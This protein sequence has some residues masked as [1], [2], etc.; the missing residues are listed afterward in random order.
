VLGASVVDGWKLSK[1]GTMAVSAQ[2]GLSTNLV[3]G[4]S[5]QV[6]ITVPTAQASLGATDGVSLYQPIEGYLI[7]RLSWGGGN[8][9]PITIG[10]WSAHHRTGIYTGTIRNSA[11][12][13][14]YAFTYTQNAPD[15][16]QYNTVTIPGDTAGTWNIDNTIGIYLT[17]AMASGSTG[18]APSANTWLAGSYFA[19]PGQINAVAAT[20]DAFRLLGVI[21]L[22]GIEAP[23]AARSP[24]IMRPQT[25]ELAI[26]QRYYEKT[27]PYADTP[28]K[29]YNLATGGGP[30]GCFLFT[31]TPYPTMQWTYKVA[32]RASPTVTIYSP[33]TGVSGMLRDQNGVAD[34][35]SAIITAGELGAIISGG[36]TTNVTAINFAFAH[37]VADARL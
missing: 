13:R 12:T 34:V 28:G 15:F 4:F 19:G 29:A 20:T 22:P 25:H 7:A 3:A 33:Y 1:S 36:G 23:S 27:Y 21:V 6:Y 16:P 24:F 26:C 10:F 30:L 8:A 18:I 35:S 31:T 11:Q 32:K 5:S 14:S 37:A 2:Q 9:Q 17:F